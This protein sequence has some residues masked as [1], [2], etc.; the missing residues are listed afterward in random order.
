MDGVR[1]VKLGYKLR[2]IQLFINN[3]TRLLGQGQL[4]ILLFREFWVN[5]VSDGKGFLERPYS[6]IAALGILGLM[7]MFEAA[8]D[9]FTA[10]EEWMFL[11]NVILVD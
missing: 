3:V 10:I 5:V 4:L 8:L 2:W 6:E 11:Q 7:L 9:N 1:S